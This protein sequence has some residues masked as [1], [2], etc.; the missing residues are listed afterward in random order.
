MSAQPPLTTK[1]QLPEGVRELCERIDR[2]A[3]RLPVLV[4]VPDADHARLYPL[5]VVRE[6]ATEHVRLIDA[7]LEGERLEPPS[8]ALRG[9][10]ELPLEAIHAAADYLPTIVFLPERDRLHPVNLVPESVPERLRPCYVAVQRAQR[11]AI[12]KAPLDVARLVAADGG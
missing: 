10:H 11:T 8:D 2:V 1:E 9:R 4:F 12:G 6:K 7:W 3:E 5:V